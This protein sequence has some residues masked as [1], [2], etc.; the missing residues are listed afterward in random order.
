MLTQIKKQRKFKVRGA[1][2]T[3]TAQLKVWVVFA[4]THTQQIPSP[5]R[6]QV[7]RAKPGF[8]GLE[9]KKKHPP[10]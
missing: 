2:P 3:S 8:L 6:N 10:F 5:S 7:T 1:H 4:R 9:A